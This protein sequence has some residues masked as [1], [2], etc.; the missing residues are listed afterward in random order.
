MD[1]F[2]INIK[3]LIEWLL[4]K[5][6]RGSKII[7]FIYDMLKYLRVLLDSFLAWFAEKEEEISVNSQTIIL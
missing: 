2:N 5:D 4:P 1:K 6:N 3:V 7:A